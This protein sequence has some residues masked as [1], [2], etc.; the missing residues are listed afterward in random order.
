MKFR[1]ALNSV[2][3]IHRQLLLTIDDEV[4]TSIDWGFDGMHNEEQIDDMFWMIDSQK[5]NIQGSNDVSAQVSY[6]LGLSSHKEGLN[7]ISVED[8]ENMPNSIDI[9]VHD[10][11]ND[12]Y[13]NLR[14]SDFQFFLPGGEF[15]EK[16]ELTFGILDEGT[17]NT[18]NQ[19]LKSLEVFYANQKESLIIVNPNIIEINSLE[20]VNMLGQSITIINNISELDYSEYQV[21]NLS[22]GTYIIKMDT[23]SGSVSKK[24][25]VN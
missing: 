6:P 1:I 21:E 19:N 20:I 18:K 15:L 23:E 5:F 8:L 13:H 22:A 4:T 11:E 9:Y 2:G 10:I 7:T 12:T 17:L 24:V 14:E 16:F 3:D 25:L